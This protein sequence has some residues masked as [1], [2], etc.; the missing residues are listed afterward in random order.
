MGRYIVIRIEFEACISK[1]GLVKIEFP[2]ALNE[3]EKELLKVRG[4]R[5]SR[6]TRT[7]TYQSNGF[8][9]GIED[10]TELVDDPTWTSMQSA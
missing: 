7:W 2:R 3:S 8:Y 6:S 9:W 5:G 4:F 10:L 1:N